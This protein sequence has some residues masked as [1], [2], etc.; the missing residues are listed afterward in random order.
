MV[1][2]VDIVDLVD[3]VD[4]VDVINIDFMHPHG[5]R[6]HHLI[7]IIVGIHVMFLRKTLFKRSQ[8]LLHLLGDPAFAK[9]QQ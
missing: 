4:L 8:L 3:L 7:G 5:P 6:K 1:S 9:L 2:L